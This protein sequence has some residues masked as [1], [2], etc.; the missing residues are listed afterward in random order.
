[1][2]KVVLGKP[3]KTFTVPVSIPLLDGTTGT[4]EVTYKYRTRSEFAAFVDTMVQ[5]AKDAPQSAS[6]APANSPA[7]GAPVDVF[8]T[9]TARLLDTNTGYLMKC[10]E[11]WNLDAEFNHDNLRALC[12]QIPQ[13]A[14]VLMDTYRDA[15]QEGRLGNSVQPQRL[16]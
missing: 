12:D 16:H 7:A 11:G 1:M 8:S 13:A 2:A 9:A 15:V 14:A 3:P 10:M 6:E 4:M 5:A